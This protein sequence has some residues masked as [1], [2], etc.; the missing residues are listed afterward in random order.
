LRAPPVGD[1]W[2][3]TSSSVKEERE[4]DVSAFGWPGLIALRGRRKGPDC[5]GLGREGE[6]EQRAKLAAWAET[7]RK[8]ERGVR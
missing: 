5:C 8:R 3:G 6:R 7:L 4:T 2:C 1:W